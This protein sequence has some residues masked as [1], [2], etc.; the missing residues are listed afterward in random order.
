MCSRLMMN[1]ALLLLLVVPSL[2]VWAPTRS[3]NSSSS[4]MVFAHHEQTD[5]VDVDTKEPRQQQQQ[6]YEGII[7]PD[8]LLR[9]SLDN[10][11]SSS[12]NDEEESSVNKNN[13]IT[14]NVTK[15]DCGM[16]LLALDHAKRL[17][18]RVTTK[19]KKDDDDTVLHHVHEALRLEAL[20]GILPPPS[21]FSSSTSPTTSDSKE[22]EEEEDAATSTT[23]GT[24]PI[25]Q[26]PNHYCIHVATS[27]IAKNAAAGKSFST[28]TS[29]EKLS[30]SSS[31]QA[32]T[33]STSSFRRTLQETMPD[34]PTTTITSTTIP[35][36]NRRGDDERPA[37][38]SIHDAIDYSRELRRQ[39][40]VLQN[41]TTMN[42][43]HHQSP[44]PSSINN[45][46]PYYVIVLGPGVHEL[47]GKPLKLSKEDSGLTIIGADGGHSNTT[48]TTTNED[49]VVWLSGGVAVQNVEF[50]PTKEDSGI[51]VGNL[52]TL[53]EGF[54]L[55]HIL[56]LFTT[57]RRW[58]RARYPNADPETDQ[59][60]YASPNRLQHS[61]ASQMVVE[62]HLPPPGPLPNFTFIDFQDDSSLPPGVP[63]KNDSTQRGYNWYASGT[64]GVCSEV[65]G[66]EADSY[67]CSNA[68]QGGWAEVDKECATTGQIQLP[69]GLTYNMSESSELRRFQHAAHRQLE[70]G[71]LHAWHS[72]SWALH[73]FDIT[74][75]RPETGVIELAK[76]GGRQGGRNWCRCDQCTYAA[77]WCGQHQGPDAWED[78]RLISGNWMIENVRAELDQVGE[79]YFDRDT[80]LLYVKPNSTV[81]LIDFRV[82]LL[83]QIL[84]VTDGASNIT[85]E[86]V[87]FRDTVPTYHP[88][89]NWSAPSGGDWSLHRGGAIFLENV[90]NVTIRGCQFRRLDG[91]AIFLSRK[92]RNVSIEENHFEW[93]GENA[94]ATWGDTDGYDATAEEFPLYTTIRSNVMRELGIFEKQSS[95]V[96]QAKAGHTYII[97]NIMFNMPRAAINFNDMVGGGDI[98][99][100]NLIF[101]TCRE[102]GDHGPI[103]S[104]DRQPFLTTL[105][106]GVTKSFEPLP[107]EINENFIIANYGASQGVD[108]DDGS[109]WFHIHHNLF[110][111]AEGFKMD[112]GTWTMIG[113]VDATVSFQNSLFSHPIHFQN[114]RWS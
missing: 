3:S 113:F 104:W 11:V 79:Y 111:S 30:S 25:C 106:D 71:I 6:Q 29:E 37:F 31:S 89:S 15:L 36:E 101:N 44:P 48:N 69:I 4:W 2:I 22:E 102:S 27:S 17:L 7:D 74:K 78:T 107:R 24:L 105:R 57:T 16:R 65:W 84:E 46:N 88:K 75:H 45:N 8:L 40:Y 94:I 41:N 108:N 92:T 68:S 61:I 59:W 91:N 62:W 112:Y 28:T 52:T 34:N 67:W 9:S 96:G 72:Q 100:G 97:D 63:R 47:R 39:Y 80:K 85:I 53:L 90:T 26:R 20:C 103:N 35:N 42:E 86:N 93:L 99:R 5:D 73:M 51:Y 82:G 49:Q 81:D 56:P 55:P 109:S 38:T 32:T 50:E 66:V 21:S 43:H 58:I 33:T 1:Y 70:G 14:I 12:F 83:E 13:R 95:A 87:G 54:D 110:Y 23:T 60:G 77:G 98:V 114:C 18:L 19:T 10:T 64:G 76:G